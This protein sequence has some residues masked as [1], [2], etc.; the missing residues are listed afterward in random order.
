MPDLR[1][2]KELAKVTGEKN[3]NNLFKRV[4]DLEQKYHTQISMDNIG[5]VIQQ[6]TQAGES[7][8]QA[9]RKT[10]VAMSQVAKVP[11]APPTSSRFI[12]PS[13]LPWEKTQ[14]ARLE[15]GLPTFHAASPMSLARLAAV[16]PEMGAAMQRIVRE[17]G[18]YMKGVED[19]AM[20]IAKQQAIST[21]KAMELAWSNVFIRHA[22]TPDIT[23]FN[24]L[25][26][27]AP[28]VGGDTRL[29]Q[30]ILGDVGRSTMPLRPM[31]I[32]AGSAGTLT[33]SSGQPMV[34]RQIAP[35]TGSY[36]LPGG[37]YQRVA[38]NIQTLSR[39]GMMTKLY[40]QG[41]TPPIFN[42]LPISTQIAMAQSISG[43]RPA[44]LTEFGAETYDWM[45]YNQ[46]PGWQRKNVLGSLP[47]FRDPYSWRKQQ[48]TW[49][50]R[51]ADEGSMKMPTINW[52]G[53]IFPVPGSLGMVASNFY[54]NYPGN[55]GVFRPE[56]EETLFSQTQRAMF[57]RGN[58]AYGSG[59]N[60]GFTR[61][62]NYKG[63]Y[64]GLI[65]NPWMTGEQMVAG[66]M[67][68]RENYGQAGEQRYLGDLYDFLNSQQ[69]ATSVGSRGTARQYAG[70]AGLAIRTGMRGAYSPEQVLR[71]GGKLSSFAQRAVTP[72]MGGATSIDDRIALMSSLG[73]MSSVEG[74]QVGIERAFD[75]VGTLTDKFDE[76]N[77]AYDKFR[78]WMSPEQKM[79]RERA[80]RYEAINRLPPNERAAALQAEEEKMTR[81][82]YGVRKKGGGY[83]SEKALG[84][85]A[86]KET[87]AEKELTG[88]G[89]IP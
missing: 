51:R 44:A 59:E 53:N 14:R 20:R 11:S 78:A 35:F 21:S 48:S 30:M 38:Q 7:F 85:G 63:S 57:G 34:G 1:V 61:W 86:G 37:H 84:W 89:G 67:P 47:A 79:E 46:S 8:E 10:T 55:K 87:E 50:P 36:N 28:P 80:S 13:E 77:V 45:G 83:L 71:L 43:I 70:A 75:Q 62:L 22:V 29:M 6:I 65:R 24:Q 66:M 31:D 81:A 23:T 52:G 19:N 5:T 60:I 41:E 4:E 69:V 76:I 82:L 73:G 40:R 12:Y 74:I 33:L 54:Y 9:G 42:L 26:L 25:R 88:V 18:Y 27:R 58:A 15:G 32:A 3:L 72:R 17:Q 68:R 64:Q 39:A 49:A 16:N 2:I 56:L